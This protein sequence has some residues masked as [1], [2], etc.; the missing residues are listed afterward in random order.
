[1]EIHAYQTTF[2]KENTYWWHAARREIALYLRRY[3]GVEDDPLVL[4]IGCGTGGLSWDLASLAKVVS[5]DLSHEA[6]RFCQQKNLNKLVQGNGEHLP[7]Q[8]NSCD[9]IY[10]LDFLEHLPNDLMGAK[11]IYRCLKPKTGFAV[12]TVPAYRFLWSPMDELAHHHRRYRRKDL[13]KLLSEAGFSITQLSYANFFLFPLALFFKK[14]ER[15]SKR[16]EEEQFLPT[17]PSTIN[18]LF[19]KIFAAEKYLLP[20]VRFPFGVSLIAILRKG[21]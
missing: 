14:S 10:A 17:L 5:L 15:K 6:L 21:K 8:N 19:K 16:K 4:N 11:E 13:S 9:E 18:T 1:M 7:F 20:R 12:I 3:Y 2:E